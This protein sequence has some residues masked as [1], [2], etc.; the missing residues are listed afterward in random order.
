MKDSLPPLRSTTNS[1]YIYMVS[2]PQI[3]K[4]LKFYLRMKSPKQETVM[5]VYRK[6]LSNQIESGIG[7]QKN[8]TITE[9]IKL[10]RNIAL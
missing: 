9:I 8:N 7:T 1:R 4:N 3:D 6:V 10:N 5:D 2:Q